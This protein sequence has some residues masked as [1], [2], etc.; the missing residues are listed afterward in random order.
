MPRSESNPRSRVRRPTATL[1]SYQSTCTSKSSVLVQAQVLRSQVQVRSATTLYFRGVLHTAWSVILTSCISTSL[2]CLDHPMHFHIVTQFL[3]VSS[4]HRQVFDWRL[5][6]LVVFVVPLQ[7]LGL[8]KQF[9]TA[10]L[11]HWRTTKHEET[12]WKLS[13][14]KIS[15]RFSLWHITFIPTSVRIGYGLV[16]MHLYS[17][18]HKPLGCKDYKI[19]ECGRGIWRHQL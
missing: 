9:T 10:R 7:W 15:C 2:A 11:M 8:S 18:L 16:D 1:P 12:P 19:K 5:R 6:Y 13:K 14:P 4:Q 17:S 3:A